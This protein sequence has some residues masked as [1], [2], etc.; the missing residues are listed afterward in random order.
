MNT[1]L[2]VMNSATDIGLQC[3]SVSHF[4]GFISLFALCG[5]VVLICGYFVQIRIYPFVKL[6]KIY[7]VYL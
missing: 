2:F 6:S 5:R 4:P 1:F 7:E 3:M